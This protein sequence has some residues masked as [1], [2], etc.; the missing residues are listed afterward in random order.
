MLNKEILI[1]SWCSGYDPEFRVGGCLQGEKCPGVL[2]AGL[3]VG[4]GTKSGDGA[5]QTKENLVSTAIKLV[6]AVVLVWFH[7]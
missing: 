6:S 7:R 4:R 1:I 5:S 3:N 2:A